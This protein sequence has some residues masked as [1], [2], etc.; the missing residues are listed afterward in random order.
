MIEG[1]PF[2]Y[3]AVRGTVYY[4]AEKGVEAVESWSTEET[5]VAFVDGDNGP[6][7]ILLCRSVQ[8]IVA[9]SPKGAY[10]KWIKQTGHASFVTKLA[11][12][13]YSREELLLTGLV[14][15]LLSTL[16]LCLSVGSSFVPLISLSSCSESRPRISATI[17]VDALKLPHPSLIWKLK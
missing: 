11:V 3:Q 10:Q 7:E 17:L 6:D 8:L 5:T 12:K 13:L 15:A 1:R 2:L 4:V 14:L 16:D 9:S